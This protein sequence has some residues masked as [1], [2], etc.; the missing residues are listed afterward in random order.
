MSMSIVEKIER[1]RGETGLSQPDFAEK[2]GISINTYKSLLKRNGAPRF[3]LVETIAAIWPEY[4]LWLLTNKVEPE[5]G[6]LEPSVVKTANLVH[7]FN[8]VDSADA[9][10]MESCVI[11]PESLKRLIFIQSAG[12]KND[13]GAIITIDNGTMYQIS[14]YPEITG[15]IWV[16]AGN[17]NFCSDGGGRSALS[18]FRS[19]LIEVNRDLVLN[20]ELWKMR[21]HYFDEIYKALK[22]PVS[23]LEPVDDEFILSRFEEWKTGEGY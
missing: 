23:T 6:Q 18:T 15:C 17:M 16:S 4:S 13:L 2:I 7:R 22:V 5:N 20:A 19:W 8:I 9:R 21:G 12:D 10:F 1:I 3:D 14:N 11:K